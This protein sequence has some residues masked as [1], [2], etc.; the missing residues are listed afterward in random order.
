LT[1]NKTL[2]AS[3]VSAVLLTGC[4]SSGSDNDGETPAPEP[5]NSVPVAT[6]DTAAT[7]NGVAIT[8]DV[9]A[10][11]TDGDNDALTITSVSEAQ[12][13][14]VE[15]ADGV[16]SYTPTQTAMGSE[17]LTYEISDGTD[18]ATGTVEITHNQSIM[19]SGIVTDSP[20]ANAN[21]TVT[22]GSES[23]TT[24]AGENGRYELSV[25]SS[26]PDAMVT[27][28]G[29]GVDTQSQVTLVSNGGAFTNLLDA[30][31]TDDARE[32]NDTES[33][34]TKVTHISTALTLLFNDYQANSGDE[35]YAEWSSTVTAEDVLNLAGF[36]KLLVDNPN[37]DI[38]EGETTLSMFEADGTSSSEVVFG[39][40]EENGLIDE[41]GEP[42][43]EYLADRD[44]AV[45]ETLNDP[46]LKVAFTDDDVTGKTWAN[47]FT[48]A[49]Q[50]RKGSVLSFGDALTGVETATAQIGFAEPEYREFEYSVNDGD[51]IVTYTAGN[52]TQDFPSCFSSQILT[53]FD[54]ET[55]VQIEQ[56]CERRGESQVEVTSTLDTSTFSLLQQSGANHIASRTDVYTY[57]AYDFSSS[58]T[59]T[60][61]TSFVTVEELDA[62]PLTN[63][64]VMQG[65]WVM[66]VLTEVSYF[67]KGSSEPVGIDTLFASDSLTFNDGVVT[68]RIT[69]SQGSY[70]LTDGTLSVTLE[71]TTINA[72]R[73]FDTDDYTV[74]LY[75]MDVNGQTVSWTDDFINGDVS[76]FEGVEMGQEVP[77]IWTSHIFQGLQD[78]FIG[79]RPT[80]E[81]AYGFAVKPDGTAGRFSTFAGDD[82][83]YELSFDGE[84]LNFTW[85]EDGNRIVFDGYVENFYERQRVWEVVNY[86]EDGYLTVVEYFN[87]TFS[88]D[89][90]QFLVEPRVNIYKL[91]DWSEIFPVQWADYIASEAD[92][93]ASPSMSVTVDN[94]SHVIE[95]GK[96]AY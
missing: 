17:T 22:V 79:D 24:T 93:A 8:I 70:T 58:E 1:F 63:E 94:E 85:F 68:G 29:T 37:Y 50:A 73:L 92:G 5:V 11:D 4:G 83:E 65:N 69:D 56:E 64:E 89:G 41:S 71:G 91:M 57:S 25:S 19:L 90:D 2:L 67:N 54:E 9:L 77:N 27:L 35:S 72:Q 14:S 60:S 62:K 16:L 38:P 66:P 76:T 34:V 10:N 42:T 18:S 40:L 36:I 39:Y 7:E 44:A 88:N 21:V 48:L 51:V 95:S 96:F 12:F 86:D 81:W 49:K 61:N 78:A 13:G 47:F 26:N 55:A 32:L 74:A 46:L 3:M 43:A 52:A 28:S 82:G 80:I 30:S 75:S 87:I 6:A 53:Y 15:I 59:F 23:F 45:E 31:L 84:I 33:T 20:L